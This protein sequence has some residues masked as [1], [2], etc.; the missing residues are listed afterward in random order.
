VSVFGSPFVLSRSA[1]IPS[2]TKR[3]MSSNNDQGNPNTA[4]ERTDTK[5][6]I[7]AL[8]DEFASGNTANL[9]MTK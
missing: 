9:W 7:P 3:E 5:S 4:A 8:C 2:R 1:L 6:V